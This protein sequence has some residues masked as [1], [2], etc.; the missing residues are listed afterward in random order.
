MWEFIF[1]FSFSLH[2]VLLI[3]AARHTSILLW[4][5]NC[6][7]LLPFLPLLFASTC[8]ILTWHYVNWKFI[9]SNAQDLLM[10]PCPSSVW[11]WYRIY[12]S[13]FL[14]RM[15]VMHSE[16]FYID[17][18]FRTNESPATFWFK[19]NNSNIS[20]WPWWRQTIYSRSLSQLHS[21]HVI[22]IIH[23]ILICWIHIATAQNKNKS[24]FPQLMWQ[25][26]I[27]QHIVIGW[28]LKVNKYIEWV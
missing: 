13:L 19:P 3:N 10:C 28:K 26:D 9:K 2:A 23:N 17:M 14:M 20:S 16:W 15:F 25:C 22:R 8:S 12:Y 4:H 7:L 11:Y 24:I 5:L 1:G 27:A 6:S 21:F 18:E